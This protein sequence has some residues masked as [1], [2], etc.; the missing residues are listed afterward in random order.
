MGADEK[1]KICVE[2]RALVPNNTE[3][4]PECGYPFD[5]NLT[6]RCR[7][8][9]SVI[10]SD[11]ENCP[12]CGQV[13]TVPQPEKAVD[14][15]DA[16]PS[17]LP[18]NPVADSVE[19]DTTDDGIQPP[20]PRIETV[21]PA[22]EK[23]GVI[24]EEMQQLVEVQTRA[25]ENMVRQ[26]LESNNQLIASLSGHQKESLSELQQSIE[27]IKTV[28][29]SSAPKEGKDAELLEMLADLKVAIADVASQNTAS[30]NMIVGAVSSSTAK[31]AEPQVIELPSSL[32][33]LDYIFIAII[34]ALIFSMGNL[35]IMAYV[36]RLIMSSIE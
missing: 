6:A 14:P 13:Q 12:V 32:K 5:D 4:C 19:S 21:V 15:V 30:A 31:A 28:V 2:C 36:A 35:L 11:V 16:V 17:D 1:Q 27:A 10:V 23:Q 29:E 3:N 20:V 22:P 24:P 33:W 7:S 25:I 18:E 26:V 34:V 8:C 9:N